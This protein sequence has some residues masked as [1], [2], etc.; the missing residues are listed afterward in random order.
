[1]K[2]VRVIFNDQAKKCPNL[3]LQILTDQVEEKRSL[4]FIGKCGK[5][6]EEVFK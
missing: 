6:K 2:E 3:S 1:V 4:D 5:N